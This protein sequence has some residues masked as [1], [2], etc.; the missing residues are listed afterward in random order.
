MLKVNKQFFPRA[1]TTQRNAVQLNSMQLS[2]AKAKA[3]MSR[4]STRVPLSLN[5]MAWNG[6]ERN[7]AGPADTSLL[8]HSGNCHMEERASVVGI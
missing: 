4:L 6:S 2:K 3:Q 1:R 8:C 7:G 5:R